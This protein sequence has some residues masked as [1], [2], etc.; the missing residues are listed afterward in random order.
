MATP[1]EL[2]S[3]LKMRGMVHDQMPELAV[4]ALENI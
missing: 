1:P 4:T 3:R 2:R